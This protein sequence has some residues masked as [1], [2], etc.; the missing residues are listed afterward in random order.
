M[1]KS[2]FPAILYLGRGKLTFYSPAS[3]KY[4]DLNFDTDLVTDLEVKKTDLMTDTV[5]VFIDQNKIKQAPFV[6]L[7][8]DEICFKKNFAVG[9]PEAQKEEIKKF[10]DLVP[11]ENV[12]SK[13]FPFEKGFSLY[14]VNRDYYEIIESAFEKFG[15]KADATVPFTAMNFPLPNG[16][17]DNNFL[18]EVYKKINFVRQNTLSGQVYVAGATGDK[19]D[20]VHKNRNLLIALGILGILL[21]VLIAV[22]L[23]VNP[24]KIGQK[25]KTIKTVSLPAEVVV[26]LPEQPVAA[27]VSA[28]VPAEK[29]K[30][31]ILNASGKVGLAGDTRE[32]FLV[33]GFKEITVGTSRTS[34]LNTTLVY[35][36]SVSANILDSLT[37]KLKVKFPD[38][39]T[40]Q[41]EGLDYSLILTIG[42]SN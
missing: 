20:F 26:P 16:P 23:V 41:S 22:F 30:V 18:P 28:G 3:E 33:L 19:N 38:L 31:Q 4:P 36:S 15:F 12:R 37:T 34:V 39:S 6:T 24:L 1:N 27:T 7:L 9:T 14:A 13:T 32:I 11:F 35:T 10:L 42:K 5:R 21:S 25:P 17:Q 8:A 2:N 40:Q 29:L